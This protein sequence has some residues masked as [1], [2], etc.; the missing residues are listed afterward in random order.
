MDASERL[1]EIQRLLADLPGPYGNE[2]L[3]TLIRPTE[4]GEPFVEVHGFLA[5]CG[6]LDRADEDVD[7]MGDEQQP[8]QDPAALAEILHEVD[9][10]TAVE[11]LVGLST[12]T[13]AYDVKRRDYTPA[14]ATVVM[15]GLSSLLGTEARWWSNT[16]STRDQWMSVTRYTFD[17]LVVGVGGGVTVAVLAVDED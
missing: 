10:A 16:N 3:W 11:T 7:W 4:R 5:A 17:A 1:A 15:S 13:L 2:Y 6:V 9:A 14:T 8:P 12:V